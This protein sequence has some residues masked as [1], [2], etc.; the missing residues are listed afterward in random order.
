[1][2]RKRF[3]TEQNLTKLRQADFEARGDIRR[4]NYGDNFRIKGITGC[5]SER[6]TL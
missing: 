1:M 4:D 2:P 6:K 5:L 3:I